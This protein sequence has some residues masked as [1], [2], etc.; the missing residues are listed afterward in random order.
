MESE[1]VMG[2]EVVGH[3]SR[4]SKTTSLEAKNSGRV[5]HIAWKSGL[6]EAGMNLRGLSVENFNKAEMQQMILNVERVNS[7]RQTWLASA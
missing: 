5:E 4:R 7:G 6:D 2:T 3:Q 1:L